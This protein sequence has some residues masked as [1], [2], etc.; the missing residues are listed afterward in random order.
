MKA[1]RIESEHGSRGPLAVV[2]T[3]AVA[4]IVVAAMVGFGKLRDI[5]LEQCVITDMAAQVSV[6]SGS[7]SGRDG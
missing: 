2:A 6:P 1:N 3:V 5:Y 4:V 7:R